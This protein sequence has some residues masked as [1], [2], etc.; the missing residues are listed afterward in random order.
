MHCTLLEV[1]LLES[2]FYIQGVVFG[3]GLSPIIESSRSLWWSLYF[4]FLF[5]FFASVHP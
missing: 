3:G 4:Y 2:I 1:S 5:S